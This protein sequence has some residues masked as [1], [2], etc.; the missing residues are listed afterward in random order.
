MTPKTDNVMTIEELASYLKVS[1]STLY[2]LLQEG[3][4]PG[5]KIAEIQPKKVCPFSK[6]GKAAD[7]SAELHVPMSLFSQSSFRTVNE[8]GANT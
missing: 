3:K 5:R 7:L 8:Y 1:R 6:T 4:V 2:K